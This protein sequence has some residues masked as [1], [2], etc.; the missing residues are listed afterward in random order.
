[1]IIP[2]ALLRSGHNAQPTIRWHPPKNPS[3]PCFALTNP[4]ERPLSLMRIAPRRLFRALLAAV[5][6]PILTILTIGCKREPTPAAGDQ[7]L[8]NYRR[9]RIDWRAAAGQE[10]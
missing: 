1:M 5:A 4:R 3:R 6:L 10:L 7:A 9:A 8:A 2:S